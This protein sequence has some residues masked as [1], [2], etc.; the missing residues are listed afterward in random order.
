MSGRGQGSQRGQRGQASVELAVLLPVMVLMV[1]L[2]LQAGLAVRDRMVV[3]HATR[4]AARAVIVEPDAGAA[5]AALDRVGLGSR[6][7]VSLSGSL[8]PGGM[9]T[10]TV[11]MSPT[12]VPVVGRVV[13]GTAVREQL[14]VMIEG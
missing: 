14:T 13:A 3:L 7:T 9:A 8:Q 5:R 2:A 1:L 10:V 6:T 12:V 4:T 11:V